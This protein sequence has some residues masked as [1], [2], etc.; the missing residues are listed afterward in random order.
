MVIRLLYIT[1]ILNRNTVSELVEELFETLI[2]ILRERY[3][4][5][6][7]I[8]KVYDNSIEYPRLIVNDYEPVVINE[9]PPLEVLLKVLLAID[10]FNELT[11]TNGVENAYSESFV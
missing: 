11:I 6:V 10:K 4:V 8:R 3:G 2:H 9:P 1:L 5:S 7:F